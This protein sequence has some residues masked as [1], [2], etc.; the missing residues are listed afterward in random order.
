MEHF[1]FE[2]LFF[3]A[4]NLMCDADAIDCF[5]EDGFL[6]SCHKNDIVDLIIGEELELELEEGDIGDWE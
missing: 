4:A 5:V 1:D 6:A 2:V 3:A